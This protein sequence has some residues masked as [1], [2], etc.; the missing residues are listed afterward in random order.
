MPRTFRYASLTLLVIAMLAAAVISPIT[1]AKAQDF[2][3]MKQEAESCD[4]AAGAYGLKSIEAID[5]LTVKFTLCQSDPAFPTKAAFSAFPINSSDYLEQTGGGGDLVDQPIGTGPYVLDTW[6]RG[7]SL[8]LQAYDG[9]WGEA[10]K[11]PTLVFRWNS[12]GAARLNELQAGTVDGIDNPSPDDFAA[13]RENSDLTLYDRPPLNIFYIGYNNTVEPFT[14]VRVREALAMGIDRQ[15]L[16]DN[17]YP[18]GSIVATQFMPPSIFGYTPEVSW[19]N[20]DPEA[21]RA[22]LADAGYP[23]GFEIELSYRDVVRP[24]LPEPGRV[25]EDLQAQLSENLGVTVNINVMESGAFID[26]ANAGELPFYLLGW[27]ADYPDATNFLDYHF[28]SGATPQFGDKFPEITEPLAAAGQLSDPQARLELYVQANQAI[29]DLVPMIPVA[30]GA[31]ATAFRSAITGAHASPLG[32]EYFAVV[33]NPDADQLVWM[34]NAEPIGLYCAD[35]TDGESLRACEQIS[36]ALLSYEVGGTAVQP[37]LAVSYEG[38]D[39]ATE[40]TFHLREGV[41][42]HDGSTLDANDVVLSYVVQW[43]ASNPLHVGRVGDFAYFNALFGSFLNA[44]A[45]E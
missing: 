17:F 24:Y 25:A 7:D 38:N 22:L 20:F 16:V 36:E 27:N 45:A 13:I 44:P 29:K 43:D 19:Y 34:Q 35:E 37:G 26:A 28:G 21:A 14:D 40:W 12:E 42:F 11:E 39:D 31:S 33:E 23:D 9:Y 30:H 10:P 32:N 15:R 6:T 4:Y 41:T 3:P 8:T 5:E 2:E 1:T 18:A